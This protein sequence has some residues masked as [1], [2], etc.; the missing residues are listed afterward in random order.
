M[1]SLLNAL[2]QLCHSNTELAHNTWLDLFPRIWKI[3]TDRQQ[4]VSTH[5]YWD[6]I[7]GLCII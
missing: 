2:S 6:N 5:N 7:L 3:L 1:V 4:H